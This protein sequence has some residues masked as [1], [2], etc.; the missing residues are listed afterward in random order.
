MEKEPIH[1]SLN[2]SKKLMEMRELK[3][4]LDRGQV[5]Y[6]QV[7]VKERVRG[8]QAVETQIWGKTQD[9]EASIS[10]VCSQKKERNLTGTENY[11]ILKQYVVYI[12]LIL[13]QYQ[14]NSMIRNRFS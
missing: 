9:V 6:S 11:S 5:E 8:E 2:N 1:M 4:G 12:L 13:K 14:T 3:V 7:Q 10:M